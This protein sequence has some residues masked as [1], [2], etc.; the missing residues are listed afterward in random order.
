MSLSYPSNRCRTVEFKFEKI[1]P[2]QNRVNTIYGNQIVLPRFYRQEFNTEVLRLSKLFGSLPTHAY[3][4]CQSAG[5]REP[6]SKNLEA[7]FWIDVVQMFKCVEYRTGTLLFTMSIGKNQIKSGE[8]RE[9]F[10]S[11]L[12][13]HNNYEF[14]NEKN[15]NFATF[16][17]QPKLAVLNKNSIGYAKNTTYGSNLESGSAVTVMAHNVQ[18]ALKILIAF[19]DEKK[20]PIQNVEELFASNISITDLCRRLFPLF[21]KFSQC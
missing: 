19:L 4:F 1:I 15:T 11:R 18:D 14:G 20:E 7:I 12:I 17:C 21:Q 5:S 10:K 8:L 16:I 13:L 6:A 2:N 3:Y 9:P